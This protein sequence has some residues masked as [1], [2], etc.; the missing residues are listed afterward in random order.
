M[1]EQLRTT[2]PFFFLDIKMFI[3]VVLYLITFIRCLDLG[4][5]ALVVF[6]L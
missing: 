4:D 2:I 1:F 6:T 5:K 3:F